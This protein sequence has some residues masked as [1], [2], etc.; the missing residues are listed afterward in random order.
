MIE[1]NKI[2][3]KTA[4]ISQQNVLPTDHISR[5]T[6][7]NRLIISQNLCLPGPITSFLIDS[8]A[9]EVV[10]LWAHVFDHAKG[11]ETV[12]MS[13][14]ARLGRWHF[15]NIYLATECAIPEML[16]SSLLSQGLKCSICIQRLSSFYLLINKLWV[17]HSRK[18]VLTSVWKVPHITHMWDFAVNLRCRSHTLPV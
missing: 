13:L 8:C 18:W 16:M 7:K 12:H 10:Y 9:R 4:V 5:D 11:N 2:S 14:I 15:V 1:H 3:E 6:L 17:E